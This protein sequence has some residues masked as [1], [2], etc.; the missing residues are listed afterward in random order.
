MK[1]ESS[2]DMVMLHQLSLSAEKR[3]CITNPK[4]HRLH[5]GASVVDLHLSYPCEVRPERSVSSIASFTAVKA[6]CALIASLT[7]EGAAVPPRD[8]YLPVLRLHHASAEM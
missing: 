1:H 7:C 2:P 8:N 5:W 6:V 3:R 4:K